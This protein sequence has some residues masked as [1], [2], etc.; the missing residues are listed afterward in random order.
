[1]PIIHLTKPTLDYTTT[2]VYP[3]KKEA[4]SFTFFFFRPSKSHHTNQAHIAIMI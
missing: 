2:L 3:S 1:M 4:T